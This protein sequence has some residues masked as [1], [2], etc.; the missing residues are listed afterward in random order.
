MNT[1]I[2]NKVAVVFAASKGLGKACAMQLARE[3]CRVAI[4]SR[5]EKRITDAANAISSATGGAVFPHV[6]D[7]ENPHEINTFLNATHQKW[8]SIDILVTN[9]GGPP[10][11]SFSE[12][13]D[14]EWHKYFNIIF[15]SVVTAI[16]NVIP[17]MKKQKWGRIIN[18]TSVSVKEP[19]MNLIYS[20]ALRLAVVGL[21]KTLSRELG[22]AGI[23]V[24]NVAPGFHAT[25]GLERIVKKRLENGEKRADIFDQWEQSVPLKR[26]GKPEEL[27]ALV[28]FL[29]SENSSYMTG[30]T[31]QVDGGRYAGTL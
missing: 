4:C 5:D 3:G 20:N 25:E 31:I 7:V 30:T 18:I 2:K 23:T 22:P 12:T 19:I 21:A 11:K 1:N 10:V 24:H 29:A 9:A 26:I 8:G 6:V 27:A 15:M 28:A 14:A 13:T 16:R 17:G